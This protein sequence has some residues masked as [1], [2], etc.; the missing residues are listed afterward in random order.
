MSATGTALGAPGS[1]F[2]EGFVKNTNGFNDFVANVGAAV[3]VLPSD[4]FCGKFCGNFTIGL[5]LLHPDPEK[6]NLQSSAAKMYD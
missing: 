4:V 1:G 2:L 6:I 3:V 5:F